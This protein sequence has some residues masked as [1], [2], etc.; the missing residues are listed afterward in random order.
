MGGAEQTTLV[1][2]SAYILVSL[3]LLQATVP[4]AQNVTR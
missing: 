3:L 4:S 2:V 1:A